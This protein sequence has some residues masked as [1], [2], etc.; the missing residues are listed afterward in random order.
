MPNVEKILETKSTSPSRLYFAALQDMM[1]AI[2]FD[3]PAALTDA[4]N[5]LNKAMLNSLGVAELIGAADALKLAAQVQRQEG[6]NLRADT[7]GLLTFANSPTQTLL[8]RVTF[9]EAVENLIARVP[10]TL[11]RAAERTA[12]NIARLYGDTSGGVPRIAFVRSAEDAVTKRAQSL[13][14]EAIEKGTPEGSFIEGGRVKLGAGRSLVEGVEAVRKITGPWTEGYAKM[15]FRTNLNTAVTAGRFRQAQDPDIARVIPA[16]E[17][18]TAGDVDVRDNHAAG[19]GRIFAVNDA[20]WLTH[21]PPL[22]WNCRC[23]VRMVGSPELRRMNR[24]RRDGSVKASSVPRAWHA[25]PG[26]RHGGRPDL[27]LGG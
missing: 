23:T 7:S 4:R 16:F 27:F 8:P 26:F 12:E 24:L 18:T 1:L 5:S 14:A 9:T 6:V 17:F 10:T 22:S 15:A 20:V 19:E 11:R 25:D 3:S 21:S 2:L 13:I